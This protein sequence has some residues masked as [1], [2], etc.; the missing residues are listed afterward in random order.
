MWPFGRDLDRFFKPAGPTSARGVRSCYKFSLAIGYSIKIIGHTSR[1]G[2]AMHSNILSLICILYVLLISCA[3]RV[4]VRDAV[5]TTGTDTPAIIYDKV[6]PSKVRALGRNAAES[7][8]TPLV[9][10]LWQTGIHQIV[11]PS[12]GKQDRSTWPQASICAN[13][14]SQQQGKR[15]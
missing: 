12:R 1:N 7:Q 10:A 14:S 6:I 11:S 4:V 2:F 5:P 3:A 15:T 13:C 9:G 8:I